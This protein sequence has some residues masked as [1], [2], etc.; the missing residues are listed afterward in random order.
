MFDP[1]QLQ[2]AVNLR[3]Q[4]CTLRRV[5]RALLA[6][7]STVCRTLKPLGLGWLKNLQLAVPVRRYQWNQPGDMIHVGTKQLARFQRVGHRRPVIEG[8]AHLLARATKSPRRHQQ[9]NP[10]SLRRGAI[11]QKAG[12]HSR[13]PAEGRGMVQRPR[14]HLQASPLGQQLGLPL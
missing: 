6:P 5:A 7:L 10:P 3:Q 2:R 13:F 14:N 12:H 4:S 11:R 8:W 1:L 9:C